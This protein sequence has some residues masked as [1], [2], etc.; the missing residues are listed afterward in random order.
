MNQHPSTNIRTLKFLIN[1]IDHSLL[2]NLNGDP[3]GIEYYENI[4]E[5]VEFMETDLDSGDTDRC[6]EYLRIQKM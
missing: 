6:K 5:Y 2:P 4:K 3:K 1:W